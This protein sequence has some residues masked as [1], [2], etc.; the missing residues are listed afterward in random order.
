MEY[1]LLIVLIVVFIIFLNTLSS[2]IDRLK[3]DLFEA[4]RKLDYHTRL[5]EK[6]QKPAEAAKEPAPEPKPAPQA[7][8]PKPLSDRPAEKTRTEPF[9]EAPVPVLPK[10]QPV[11]ETILRPTAIQQPRPVDPSAPR[12]NVV[13]PQ[14]RSWWEKFKEQNPDLEKFIGENLINKIGILILVLGISYF[15][16]Y[17][18]DKDWIG[19]PARVGIGVLAGGIVM[20]VAHRLRKNYKAF[21]SVLVAGAVSIFYFTIA[22]AFHDYQLFSQTVAFMIM[23]A[24]TAFSA[25]LSVLY[26]R[27]ELAALTLIGGFA[28]PFM[29]STG[30]GNYIVLFS[31][32]TILNVG[33]LAIAYYKK[34]GLIKLQAYVFTVLLFAGWL[35][36]EMDAGTLPYRGALA[37]AFTF[38]FVFLLMNIINNVRRKTPFSNMELSILVSNTFLFYAAGMVIL[39]N[40]TPEYKGI[41]TLLLGVFN[42]CFSWLLYKKLHIDQR[43]I[44]ILIGLTLT[45][46]TLAIPIQFEGNYITLFW[47]AEAV[48]LLWL[49]QKS[50]IESFRFGS[51][52]VQALMLISL[53]MDWMDLYYYGKSLR[54]IINPAFMTSLFAIASCFGV[55][56]LLRKDTGIYKLYG[57]SFNVANYQKI[58]GIFTLILVYT[59]GFWELS[60]QADTYLE[61]TYAAYSLLVLYHLAFC[62]VFIHIHCIGKD[63]LHEKLGTLIGIANTVAFILLFSNLAYYEVEDYLDMGVSMPLAYWLHFALLGLVIYTVILTY[64]LNRENFVDRMRNEKALPWITVFL[65]VYLASS[66]LMVNWLMIA[67]KPV[68]TAVEVIGNTVI[69]P[70]AYEEIAGVRD[71]VIKTG[72]PV[73]W[74]AIAFVLLLIGIRK[75]LRSIRIAALVLLGLTIA[76]LFLYDIRN[77]SETGKIIAFILLGILILVI[78]FLYQKVKRLV[79]EDKTENDNNE[80]V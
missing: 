6:F 29:V 36:T 19:E 57:L 70:G 5:L 17:A 54:I 22:V 37:F 64:R 41:F 40:S 46:V 68:T 35:I 14:Q 4:H 49:A 26:D 65:L 11:Q 2:K 71:H 9:P 28:V 79:T 27:Q 59:S 76:K 10:P 8:I 48:L 18:I 56:L 3:I 15:V 16:K 13:L 31:Y 34:W 45:F 63:K 58:V 47:A 21:S 32:I 42:F 61:S 73:L 44:Y 38:Y 52:I 78:S 30:S 7:E 67:I 1:V 33:I 55:I 51:A 53:V 20:L 60:F 43:A 75:Q 25:F 50:K 39:E 62:I 12:P 23:V 77:V 24:I 66:E 74:G 69:T 80:T 72:Y